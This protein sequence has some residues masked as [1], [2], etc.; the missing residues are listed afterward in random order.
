MRKP[1][2]YSGRLDE[3]DACRRETL[4]LRI[5]IVEAQ[6][7]H[8]PVRIACLAP[9][10]AV[11]A[12]AYVRS[13]RAAGQRHKAG[14]LLDDLHAK[15]IALEGQQIVQVLAPDCYPGHF[16]DHACDYSVSFHL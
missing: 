11:G 2:P 16:P 15:H 10:L 8:V 12:Q 9:H 7:N 1:S 6:A 5:Q 13:F 4:V 14:V 3:F